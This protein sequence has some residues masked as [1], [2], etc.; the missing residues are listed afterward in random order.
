MAKAWKSARTLEA[1]EGGLFTPTERLVS[2]IV[3][4]KLKPRDVDHAVLMIVHL[5][6][7]IVLRLNAHRHHAEGLK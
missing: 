1:S 7:P 4:S 3:S 2:F 6:L 5:L